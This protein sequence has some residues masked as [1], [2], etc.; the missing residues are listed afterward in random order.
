[1]KGSDRDRWRTIIGGKNSHPKHDGKHT[2]E[3]D[4]SNQSLLQRGKTL[5]SARLGHNMDL[6]PHFGVLD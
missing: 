3:N 5:D 6:S 2:E 1:M 4:G